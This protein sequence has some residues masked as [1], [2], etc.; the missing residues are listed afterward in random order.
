MVKQKNHV[1][2]QKEGNL[3]FQYILFTF[4]FC[5]DVADF[6]HAWL[7]NVQLVFLQDFANLLLNL[8]R[9]HALEVT[10]EV[11]ANLVE[12]RH[13]VFAEAQ[14]DELLYPITWSLLLWLHGWEQK[15]FLDGRLTCHQDG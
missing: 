7:L 8:L 4:D 11:V 14:F 10:H 15:H 5:N 6:V 2:L 12:H 13:D 3:D 9:I 1:T